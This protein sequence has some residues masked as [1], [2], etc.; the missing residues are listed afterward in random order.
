MGPSLRELCSLWTE[1]VPGF[2]VVVVHAG[3]GVVAAAEQEPGVSQESLERDYI[4]GVF[5]DHVGAEE[6]NLAGLVRDGAASDAAVGVQAIHAVDYL[7]GAFDLDSPEGRIE[8]GILAGRRLGGV[9][10]RASRITS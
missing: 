5:G 7:G 6:V 10:V 2:V 9:R 3:L 8:V 1:K 4:P